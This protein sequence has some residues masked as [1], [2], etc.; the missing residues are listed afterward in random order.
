M[1]GYTAISDAGRTIVEFL[2]RNCIPPVEKP[3]F[4][5]MCNP[6]EPGNFLVGVCLYDISEDAGTAVS[7]SEIVVDETHVRAAP[8]AV[9]LHYMIF[10]ALKSDIAV[11]AQDEQRILG[12]IYQRLNDSRI[13]SEGLQGAMEESGQ[14]LNITLENIAY[15][16]KLKIWAAYSVSPK[17]ALF[18]KVSAVF[19]DSEKVREVRRVTTADITLRQKGASR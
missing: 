4:I 11:R 1:A 19:I 13:I 3:E 10:T 18:Y 2:R 8:S 14:S 16:D 17:T 7:R 6:D 9:C 15:E 12:R 5:G